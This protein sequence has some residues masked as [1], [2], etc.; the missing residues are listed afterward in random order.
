MGWLKPRV[1]LRY[2]PRHTVG[3]SALP[4]PAPASA[5]APR[6][7]DL[8]SYLP[9]T[10]PVNLPCR[11]DWISSTEELQ[12][13]YLRLSAASA[14]GDKT[15]SGPSNRYICPNKGSLEL[16]R[17]VAPAARRSEL[18]MFIAGV[19]KRSSRERFVPLD[20]ASIRISRETRLEQRIA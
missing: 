16:G 9:R 11:A 10:Q 20:L 6:A 1:G 12:S 15:L 18:N 19:I 14:P 3:W 5:P 7:S 13:S 2:L 4:P 17:C 8:P